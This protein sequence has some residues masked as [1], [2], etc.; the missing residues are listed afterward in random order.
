[1]RL[2]S[3]QQGYPNST[4][5]YWW[6]IPYHSNQDLYARTAVTSFIDMVAGIAME[7]GTVVL[8]HKSETAEIVLFMYFWGQLGGFARM[9]R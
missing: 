5:I 3:I 7:L 6:L 9:W 1:M 8:S 2:F 4:P